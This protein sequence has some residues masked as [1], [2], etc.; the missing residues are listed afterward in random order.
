MLTFTTWLKQQA[1]RDDPVGDLA[2]DVSRDSY[3]PHRG[4]LRTYIQHLTNHGACEDA[5]KALKQA[6]REYE[7]YIRTSV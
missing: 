2:G 5:I 6:W 7:T 4:G 1:K 3:W